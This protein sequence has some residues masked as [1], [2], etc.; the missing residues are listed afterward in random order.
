VKLVITEAES[1]AIAQWLETSNA[2]LAT[3]RLA[4]VEVTRAVG[5]ANPDPEA[6]AEAD[7]LLASCVLIDVSDE[8]IR[9][10]AGLASSRVRSLDAIH[11]ASARRV[12]AD[13]MVVYDERL[14]GAAR[15]VG[16]PI[17]QPGRD[18][19]G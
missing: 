4:I 14:A 12:E 19:P 5:I 9:S 8:L 7:R 10:A 18:Q 3:S 17:V 16:I 2:I 1:E 15:D 13:A 11:L 6:R